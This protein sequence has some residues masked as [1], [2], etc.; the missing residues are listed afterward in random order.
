MA[1]LVAVVLL[2]TLVLAPAVSAEPRDRG[3]SPLTGWLDAFW[4]V[5]DRVF[6]WVPTIQ[7]ERRKHGAMVVPNGIT[8]DRSAP[9]GVQSAPR[10]HGAMVVPNG[11]RSGATSLEDRRLRNRAAAMSR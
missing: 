3:E 2:L 7:S 5:F 10:K 11:V 4:G 9:N 1:R 8:T 6:S